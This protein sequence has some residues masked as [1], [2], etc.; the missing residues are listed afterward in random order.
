MREQLTDKEILERAAVAVTQQPSV[1]NI[2]RLTA[3]ISVL[4]DLSDKTRLAL[5]DALRRLAAGLP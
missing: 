2:A 1:N 4:F 3:E 5:R